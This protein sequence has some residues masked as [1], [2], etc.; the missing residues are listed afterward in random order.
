VAQVVERKRGS[1]PRPINPPH[2]EG[3]SNLWSVLEGIQ[4]SNR[5]GQRQVLR[6]SR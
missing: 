4:L 6:T 2:D 5:H 1:A 3:P